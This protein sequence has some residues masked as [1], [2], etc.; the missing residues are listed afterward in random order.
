MSNPT[1]GKAVRETALGLK[2]EKSLATIADGN[3]FT[4]SGRNLVVL[5]T[6]QITTQ[7]DAG[8]TTLKLQTENGTIDLCAATTITNDDVGTMYFLT[9]ERAVIMN[10]TA[11]APIIDVA[12]NI[13]LFPSAPMIIGRKD[14]LDAI[15]QVQ[16]GE[17]ADGV[18][19]WI[20]IY[21]PLDDGAYIEAA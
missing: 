21:I 13:T 16:T 9:G 20:V 6:G 4:V 8:A 10:G 2:A 15:Q 5:I 11:N 7:A 3:L 18:I 14:T 12:T 19:A 1:Q 17:D